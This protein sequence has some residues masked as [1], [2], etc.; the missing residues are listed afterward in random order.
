MLWDFEAAKGSLM[1]AAVEFCFFCTLRKVFQVCA[2]F[3]GLWGSFSTE[4]MQIL[5]SFAVDFGEFCCA[6]LC[7][8]FLCCRQSFWWWRIEINADQFIQPRDLLHL[9]PCDY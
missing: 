2:D 7:A 1:A 8:N 9:K 6:D 4:F 5:G 3:G